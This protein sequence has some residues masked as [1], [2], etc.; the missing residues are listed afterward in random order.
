MIDI[1]LTHNYLLI[2]INL[3]KMFPIILLTFIYYF[4]F[5]PFYRRIEYVYIF[6]RIELVFIGFILL[7][8]SNTSISLLC[9]ILLYRIIKLF[10]F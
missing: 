4:S 1:L 10:G 8:Y 9:I 3:Y 7:F 6:P 5:F 2:I